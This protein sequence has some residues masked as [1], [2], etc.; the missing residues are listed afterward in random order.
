MTF[1]AA[2]QIADVVLYEG[3]VL[4][5]YRA[6]SDKNRVRFQFGVVAPRAQAELDGSEAWEMQTECLVVPAGDQRLDIRVR[7][8]QLQARAVEAVDPAAAE[9]FVAVP[10]LEVSD[11]EFVTWDESI[12]EQIDVAAR[13]VAALLE[14][15]LVVPFSLS[16]AR[17]VEPVHDAAGDLAGRI[18]RSRWPIDGRVVLSAESVGD[19][20]RVRVRLENL[21]DWSDPDA[22]R[23]ETLR[24]SLLGCHT[25]LAVSGGSFL[26]LTDPPEHAR[27]AARMSVNLHT[28]PVL[29][30]HA[31][32]AEVLL[33]S[34]IILPD[35]PE[36]APESPGDLFDATEIDEILTLRIMTLTDE[37]KRSAR[38]TD[39]R[40]RRII[41]RAD[42]MPPEMLDKLHGAIRYLRQGP[43]GQ[44]VGQV[45]PDVV[46]ADP[47]PAADMFAFDPFATGNDPFAA[48]LDDP[49]GTRDDP[50]AL[51]PSTWE[52]EA[53][54]AP[55][56][57][58]VQI[59]GHEVSKGSSVRLRPQRSADAMD[60]FLIGRVATVEAVFESVDD[61]TYVAVTIDDDPATDL[62]RAAG[63]FFYFSP[64]ELEPL[65]TGAA[66]QAAS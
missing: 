61:E 36:I 33:S 65:G 32:A 16:G 17:E 34:P 50:F 14:A 37:E 9:G 31:D 19:L 2:Q 28:W 26:S 30:G 63:R 40:A 43:A 6:S 35:H 48:V 25:L 20:V 4:Y 21:T 42:T 57:A 1:E 46:M 29:V 27:E 64:D 7:F 23:D 10:S 66:G 55:H 11:E 45:P 15:D 56:L 41:D 3:Y 58:I 38:A 60:F 51:P 13:S 39:P 8:L 5:P 62:H 18:V 12:E 59:G 22:G 53:R 54:V 49:F 44:P 52:P 24:R 47:D